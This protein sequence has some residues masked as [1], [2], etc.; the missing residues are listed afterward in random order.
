V[1]V[2]FPL[3]AEVGRLR[4]GAVLAVPSSVLAELDHLVERGTPD[5][6][7]ARA[8]AAR[9]SPTPAPGTGDDAIL[10]V[11]VRLGAWVVTADRDLRSRLNEK[12]INVLSP[13]DRHRLELFRG[14]RAPTRTPRN[15]RSGN[16]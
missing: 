2:G 7:A 11:A 15:R 10:R 13:R 14:V 9:Y 8:F 6:A 1:H 3:E 16:G 4:P 5:A 12:G